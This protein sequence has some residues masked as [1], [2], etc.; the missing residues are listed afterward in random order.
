[1]LDTLRDA[2]LGQFLRLVTR[3]RILLYPEEQEGFVLP[4]LVGI[5][6][7]STKLRELS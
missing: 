7:V 4:K 1:M 5:L 3:N 2:P 6:V